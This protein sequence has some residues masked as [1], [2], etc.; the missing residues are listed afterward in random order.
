[1][2]DARGA[3]LD[4]WQESVSTAKYLSEQYADP[5]RQ[6]VAPEF[7]AMPDHSAILTQDD[8]QQG[9][10]AIPARK[11]GPRH[12]AWNVMYKHAAPFLANILGEFM[13]R[14]WCG[15]RP[16]IPQSFKD[17]WLIML[18]KPGRLCRGPSDLRPIGLSHPLGKAM[19]RALRQKILAYA[20]QFM[21]HVPQWGF[22]PR[23]EASD[24]L[25]RAFKHCEAVRSLCKLQTLCA[26]TADGRAKRERRWQGGWPWPWI[27]PKHLILSHMLRSTVRC[28]QH[29]FLSKFDT[30]FFAGLQ[31]L[32]IMYKETTGQ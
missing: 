9:L 6:V 21:H 29:R 30:L 24:A 1:M 7:L 31:V 23:R 5:G 16:Y 25:A 13:Q 32:S 19:L 4:T 26:L 17:A 20:E 12:L 28:R 18:M 10:Q 3:I 14:W 8:V 22:M 2:R 11:A 27:S 15:A